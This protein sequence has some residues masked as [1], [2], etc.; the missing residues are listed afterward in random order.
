MLCCVVL[1]DAG[2]LVVLCCDGDNVGVWLFMRKWLAVMV[3][4]TMDCDSGR[5][6]GGGQQQKQQKQQRQRVGLT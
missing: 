3:V 4:H 5:V 1:N 2:L 6:G